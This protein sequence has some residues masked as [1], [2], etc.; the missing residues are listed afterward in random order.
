MR[1]LILKLNSRTAVTYDTSL[2]KL[3]S[4]HW[5]DPDIQLLL[6]IRESKKWSLCSHVF[7]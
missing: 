3:L 6:V 2:G 7:C 1:N 4:S 5:S